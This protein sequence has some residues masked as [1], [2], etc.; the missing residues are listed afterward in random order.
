MWGYD[1]A[2][3]P[4]A[5]RNRLRS[6]PSW[7]WR[8]RRLWSLPLRPLRDVRPLPAPAAAVSEAQAGARL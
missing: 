3:D 6:A 8:Q 7:T 5:W 2:Y 4:R 1:Q